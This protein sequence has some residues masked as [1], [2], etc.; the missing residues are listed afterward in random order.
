MR[1]PLSDVPQS[2]HFQEMADALE[3]KFQVAMSL[4]EQYFFIENDQ[5]LQFG[6]DN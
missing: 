4:A 1:R 2:V 6:P 3:M 5:S